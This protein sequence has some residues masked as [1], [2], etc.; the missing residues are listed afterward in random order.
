M[1]V[2]D[3]F[4]IFNVLQYW[5]KE[6]LEKLKMTIRFL[7]INLLVINDDYNIIYSNN[8]DFIDLNLLEINNA[9]K[10]FSFLLLLI[11]KII[12]DSI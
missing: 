10:I 11:P 3:S 1:N 4:I 7:N 6:Y 12:L 8:P 2:S 5:F 9:N